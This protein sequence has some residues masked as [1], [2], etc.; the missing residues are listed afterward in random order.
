VVNTRP[1]A[2]Q[3]ELDALLIARGAT[4]ISFPTISIEP[5]ES[6]VHLDL[7][8]RHAAAGGYA[9]VLITSANTAAVLEERLRALDLR[10]DA[11]VAAIGAVTAKAVERWLGQPVAVLPDKQHAV[12]LAA[13]TP[14]KPGDCVLI[15][16]SE[17]ARPE[18][19]Q[20]I[21][22][23]GGIPISV[24]AYRTISAPAPDGWRLDPQEFDA[25][26]FASPSAIEGFSTQL[27]QA[28]LEP[29]DLSKIAIACIGP[30]T[31]QAA[32]DNGF[33]KATQA[34]EYTIGGLVQALERA[35]TQLKWEEA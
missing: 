9:W 20:M 12:A 17:R 7:E 32:V 2:Q 26:A 33:I 27:H 22:Q 25:V 31:Y 16:G 29:G 8:L 10:I 30:T 35:I 28:G 11:R 23:Q 24:V 18:L 14:I 21:A 19:P 1:I 34:A 4:P 5:L 3:A 15:P 13:Q 6:T